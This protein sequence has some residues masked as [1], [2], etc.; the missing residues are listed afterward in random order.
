[1]SVLLW[2]VSPLV[3]IR[4]VCCDWCVTVCVLQCVCLI[5]VLLCV[6]SSVYQI[7]VAEVNPQRS[8]RQASSDCYQVSL[9]RLL[10][11]TTAVIYT[12]RKPLITV[13]NCALLHLMN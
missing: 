3:C 8:R 4:S 7:V 2:C 13:Q 1:M 10:P 12:Q 6:S 11:T 9:S 5:S